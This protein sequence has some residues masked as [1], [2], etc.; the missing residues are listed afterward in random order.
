MMEVKCK[1]CSENISTHTQISEQQINEA[2]DKLTKIKKIRLV[3]DST[4]EY[5]LSQCR[6]CKYLEFGVTCLQCGCFIRI[7]AKLADAGCPLS[8]RKRWSPI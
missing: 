1:S 8:K 7:R 2:I 3:D 5:R 6:D 4:Y